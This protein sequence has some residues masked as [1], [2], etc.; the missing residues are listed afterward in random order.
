M[1]LDQ[2]KKAFESKFALDEEKEFKAKVMASKLFGQW[3]AQEM[4]LAPEDVN[5]YTR[6]IID[7]SVTSKDLE[8][9]IDHVSDDLKNKGLK[10]NKD[11]LED[12]FLTNLES[13]RTKL[14]STN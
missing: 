7:F 11:K 3:A 6:S 5:I 14:A 2:R 1:T 13:C 4:E 9:I 8:D 10:S 12:I